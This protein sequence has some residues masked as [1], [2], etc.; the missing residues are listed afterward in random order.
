MY[1]LTRDPIDGFSA[2]FGGGYVVLGGNSYP[3]GKFAVDAMNLSAKTFSTIRE[4]VFKATGA[5]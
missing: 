1:P 3:V 2:V 4:S 5:S